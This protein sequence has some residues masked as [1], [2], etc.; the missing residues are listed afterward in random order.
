MPMLAPLKCARA[1]DHHEL[2][3]NDDKTLQIASFRVISALIAQGL[4]CRSNTI[5]ITGCL[6]FLRI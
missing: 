4:S 2:C 3:R 5:D 6:R 1:T